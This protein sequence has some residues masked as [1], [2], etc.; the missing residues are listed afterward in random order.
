MSA[1]FEK[2]LRDPQKITRAIF[3]AIPD[4]LE[5]SATERGNPQLQVTETKMRDL[6][7]GII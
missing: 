5:W 1:K 4:V 3:D 7:S 2:M 6:I